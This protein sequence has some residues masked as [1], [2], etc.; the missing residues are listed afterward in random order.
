VDGNL[1][2]SAKALSQ[3][4]VITIMQLTGY[5]VCIRRLLCCLHECGLADMKQMCIGGTAA[6]SHPL[7]MGQICRLLQAEKSR[8]DI[9]AAIKGFLAIVPDKVTKYEILCSLN[10]GGVACRTFTG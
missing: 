6:K 5:D 7:E 9:T 10:V 4:N 2:D 8:G 3:E 1:A